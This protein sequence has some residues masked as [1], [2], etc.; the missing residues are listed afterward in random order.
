MTRYGPACTYPVMIQWPR[1]F[2]PTSLKTVPR[3]FPNIRS[4]PVLDPLRHTTRKDRSYISSRKPARD[5]TGPPFLSFSTFPKSRPNCSDPPATRR[6]S[7]C[8]VFT[9]VENIPHLRIATLAVDF[10][11]HYASLGG[12]GALVAFSRCGVFFSQ[13]YPFAGILLGAIFLFLAAAENSDGVCMNGRLSFFL[14]CRPSEGRPADEIFWCDIGVFFVIT[15]SL[16]L[17]GGVLFSV[18]VYSI[19]VVM[20]RTNRRIWQTSLE[21][22]RF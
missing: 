10:F 11:S 14:S 21:R 22:F 4:L 12:T 18:H 15:F 20:V 2:P 3:L 8:L 13:M 16:S 17:H 1:Y 5:P 7:E 19:T 9:T 6:G